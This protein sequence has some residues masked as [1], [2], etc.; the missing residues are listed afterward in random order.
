M[1]S[2]KYN[3]FDTKLDKYVLTIQ[4]DRLEKRNAFDPVFVNELCDIWDNIENS[5]E[6]KIG[7]LKSK[8]EEY[9]SAGADLKQL[10]PLLTGEKKPTTKIEKKV[11]EENLLR[12]FYR[13]NKSYK[14]PIIGVSSGY[15]LAGGFELLLSCDFKII[16]SDSKI[17]FPETKLGLI[18]AGGGISRIVH[19]TSRSRA[20]EI[21]INS[22]DIDINKLL[23]DGIVNEI[24][25]KEN[26]DEILNRYI[27]RLLDSESTATEILLSSID[28]FKEL[29][30]AESFL[31]E[32]ELLKKLSDGE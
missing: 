22:S 10:I 13:K 6:I 7:V 12:K 20:L 31:L 21:L 4:M 32:E 26:L 15:C 8:S 29:N 24:C 2:K 16:S 3:F 1:E 11:I 19:S 27:K 17:G 30:L 5:D 25:A 14:K 18:P 28:N 9:F 23:H